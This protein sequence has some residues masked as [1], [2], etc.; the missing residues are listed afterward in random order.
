MINRILIRIK[1]VQMLYAYM[2]TRSEFRIQAAPETASRDKKYAYSLYVDLLL[3]MLEISGY[4]VQPGKEKLVKSVEP[5]LAATKMAKALYA[6]ND[7]KGLI[8]KAASHISD[9]DGIVM[10]LHDAVAA[11]TAFK[12]YKRKRSIDLA[13]DVRMWCAVLNTVIAG[14]ARL[15]EILRANPEFTTVGM[16]KAFE[17]LTETLTGYNDTRSSYN[18]ARNDLDRS[19]DKAYELYNSIFALI[20]ELTH[21]QAER[22]EAAKGKFLATHEDLNPNT[23]FIDNA[24][25]RRL[26]SDERLQEFIEANKINWSEDPVLVRNLLDEIIKSKVYEDY[27]AAQETD[28]ANDCE[29]WRNVLRYVIFES[30]TFAEALE[31]KSLFWND[32]LSIMGTFVL[33]TIRQ[34]SNDP[35]GLQGVTMLPQYKDEEDTEFG[36]GLFTLGVKNFDL[37]RTYIDRF[38]NTEQWDSERLA[39][40]DIV[41]MVCAIAEL[42]NYPEIPLAVTMNEYVE[43]AN[44]YSTNRSGQFVNGI[45]FSVANYLRDEGVISK[46]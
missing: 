40:M 43:I 14:D 7:I 8:L 1:V 11:S 41:V 5:K 6:D 12:D 18:A 24:L 34:M 25:A 27:M 33:K 4:T 9:Y 22:L 26:E 32:D 28:F 16:K 45:L 44:G 29:F 2:L 23:R 10:Q 3:L 31:N 42:I 35:E 38:L 21:L 46:Q 13:D 36:P 30:E 37:Y 17:M 20:V 15:N 19:L 39:F